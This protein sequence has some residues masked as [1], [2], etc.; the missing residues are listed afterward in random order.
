MDIITPNHEE[1]AD[2][3]GFK[4]SDVLIQHNNDFKQAVEYCGRNFLKRGFITCKTLIVRASK[5]GAM[6]IS[7]SDLSVI[8]WI[9]A[10]WNWK[11]DGQHVIDVT[12]AGNA[13]C[14][15]FTVGWIETDG[16][17]VEAA[18]YGAVSASYAVEQMGVPV[19]SL[20]NCK[21]EQWNFGPSPKER[22]DI[23]KKSKCIFK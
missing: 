20:K 5:Y 22:L 17:A 12:G 13:F 16:D 15:G 19:Y 6:V 7:T 8:R 10:Y 18:R 3:Q 23:L 21:N 1:L 9:P 4:F 11:T 2:M 14:G